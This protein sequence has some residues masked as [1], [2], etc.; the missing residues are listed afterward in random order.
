MKRL[1]ITICTAILALPLLAQDRPN[2]TETVL[3][4]PPATQNADSP[5]VAAAKAT[6]R[7]GKNPSM[8][9]TNETLLRSGGH[10]YTA[11]APASTEPLPKPLPQ[12]DPAAVRLEASLKAKTEADA[13]AKQ[14]SAAKKD[15]KLK[16]AAADYYGESI[17][18]RVDDPAAQ[19]HVMTQMTSTQ[20]STVTPS[21]PPL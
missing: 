1:T 6:K 11:N 8:V 10:L 12:P 14:E 20:P 4:K 5:L 19:E 13:K 7:L 16:A 9:I 15:Q 17:E 2:T 21:K 3:A 18:E